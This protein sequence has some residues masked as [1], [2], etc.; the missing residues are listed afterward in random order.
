MDCHSQVAL[1]TGLSLG[2]PIHK[3]FSEVFF[4]VLLSVAQGPLGEIKTKIE[5][6]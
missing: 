2:K 4:S 5:S 6:V 1:E 3:I